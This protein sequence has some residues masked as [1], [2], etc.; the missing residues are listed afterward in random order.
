[1]NDSQ[2]YS[3]DKIDLEKILKSKKMG[4]IKWQIKA[5]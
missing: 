5:T 3:N 2:I 1:M 4:V